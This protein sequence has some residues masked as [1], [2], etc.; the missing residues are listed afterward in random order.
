MVPATLPLAQEWHKTRI[1][2]CLP[3][4]SGVCVSDHE[5]DKGRRRVLIGLGASVWGLGV[6]GAA[7][8][9]VKSW[10]PSGKARAAGAPIRVDFSK[11]EAG[12]MLGPIPAWRGK[13]V[14]VVRRSQGMV[15]ELESLTSGLADADSK[16]E[17]QPAYAQNPTRSRKP[18]IGVYVGICTHLGCSPKYQA[19]DSAVEVTATKGG[20]FCPCHG[21]KFDLAGRVYEGVPAPANLEVPPYSYESDAVIVIGVDEEH[22]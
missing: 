10:S 9:F 5:V 16:R 19:P 3:L 13:P 17:Q 12:S 20:F 21:S 2:L 1:V 4:I 6:I 22:A 15:K 18:D 8:P 14:F 11:L 7:V